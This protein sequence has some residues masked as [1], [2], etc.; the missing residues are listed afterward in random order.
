MGGSSKDH[1]TAQRMRGD[2]AG[3]ENSI[4][5]MWLK[6]QERLASEAKAAEKAS[7]HDSSYIHVYDVYLFLFYT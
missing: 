4:S 7:S 1:G 6:D 2:D 3:H 5:F